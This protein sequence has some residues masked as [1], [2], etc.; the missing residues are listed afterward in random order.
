MQPRLAWRVQ[1]QGGDVDETLLVSAQ[2]GHL[3][4]RWSNNESAAATGTGKTLYYGN[5]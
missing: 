2:D 5:V 1:L 3:L 4:D